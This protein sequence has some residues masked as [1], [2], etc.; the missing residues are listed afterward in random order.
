[1]GVIT[2]F[3]KQSKGSNGRIFLSFVHGYRIN[4]KV[5]HKTIEK[6]GYLDELEKIYDDPIAHFKAIAKERNA[7]NY[8]R[9]KIEIDIEKNLA[10]NENCRKNLGYAIPKRIYSLLGI[11][12]FFQNKQKHLNIDYNLNSIFSL[13]VFRR[14]LFPGSKKR[15][16]EKR[17][18]FFDKYDF[19]LDD[20]YRSLDHFAAY[21]EPLQKFL[22]EQICKTI[23]RDGKLGYYDVTNYYFE[24]P[25][26]DEDEYDDDGNLVKKGLRKK[27]P[28]KEHRPDPIVQ[29]GLLMDSNGI[30]MAFNTFSGAES[31]KKSLLPLIRR[32]KRD[33]NL[34]RIIVVADRGLNT[35]DNT[36]FLAGVN[37]DDSR[38]YDGYVYGQSVLGADKEFKEWVLNPD[39]YIK[40]IE[41]DKNGDEYTVKYK[42]RIYA[43]TIQLENRQG[44]RNL[45]MT[46]YQKQLVFYSE[47]YAKKQEKERDLVIKK[48]LDLIANPGKYTRATSVGA[49]GYVKNIKFNKKTGEIADGLNLLLDIEKI[50]EEE[51][52]DGY[53]SI[54]TSEKHLSDQEIREIYRQ[55]WEIED[56][57]KITKSE[58]KTRPIFVRTREHINAHFLVCFVALL[59]L[60]ILEFKL[61]KKYS[62][63]RIRESLIE[64][65]CTYIEQNI[66]VFNYR[67]EI[68]CSLEKIFDL[69]LKKKYMSTSEIKKILE[70]HK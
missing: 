67:D 51:K 27:G 55:L 21:S 19:S 16:F 37:D 54:V 32:V 48:A 61:G 1:M 57:F 42:S 50:K 66:H 4:G 40:T 14:I 15:D 7:K 45:K 41:T 39:G 31:E 63:R 8:A 52:F 18:F 38:G 13:L 28:S 24:I 34:E 70:Y 20:V 22:H 46:I 12:K 35:S 5:K 29:M 60:R 30:P 62:I 58:L 23:G 6:I 25:Y 59:I 26:D 64:Y 36:A 69:N 11:N 56:S 49:A 53:Y 9:K 17:D 47:K 33:Y 44:K 68:L 2:I 43:K 3:L 10:D 65:S